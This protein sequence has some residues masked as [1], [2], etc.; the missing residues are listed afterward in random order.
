MSRRCTSLGTVLLLMLIVVLGCGK[1]PD[2]ESSTRQTSGRERAK[3]RSPQGGTASAEAK[4]EAQQL[5]GKG[6]DTF[7]RIDSPTSLFQGVV[8]LVDGTVRFLEWI[9]D[10]EPVF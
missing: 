4:Q 1:A 5:C 9:V 3:G 8:H 6:I 10:G 2:P 7:M